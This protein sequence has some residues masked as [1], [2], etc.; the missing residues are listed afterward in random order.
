MYPSKV[1]LLFLAGE[2]YNRSCLIHTNL[3]SSVWGS[4]LYGI[5]L[6]INPNENNPL[7]SPRTPS[8]K[9]KLI[10]DYRKAC[11]GRGGGYLDCNTL[12]FISLSLNRLRRYSLA[13]ALN[14]SGKTSLPTQFP[15]ARLTFES[16]SEEGSDST[17]LALVLQRE[18]ARRLTFL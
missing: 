14:F 17:P 5:I 7:P 4:K 10:G 1:G 3:L 6:L 12:F 15:L 8:D 9:F 13:R 16:H 2:K 11:G 18:P